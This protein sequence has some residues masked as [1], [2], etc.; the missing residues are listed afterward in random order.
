VPATLRRGLTF[1]LVEDVDEVLNLAL[2]PPPETKT[3]TTGKPGPR[4]FRARP[5]RPVTV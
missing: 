4:P 3:A 5:R 2:V 1:H